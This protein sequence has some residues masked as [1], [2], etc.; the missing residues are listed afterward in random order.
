MQ[1]FPLV[2]QKIQYMHLHSQTTT[3]YASLYRTTAGKG[4]TTENTLALHSARSGTKLV[5][6]FGLELVKCRRL[7]RVSSWYIL[8]LQSVLWMAIGTY[9]CPYTAQEQIIFLKKTL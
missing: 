7:H 6:R 8:S 9:A 2:P 1:L 5:R 4:Y 3:I